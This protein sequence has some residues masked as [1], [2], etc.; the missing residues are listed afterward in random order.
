MSAFDIAGLVFL[1]LMAAFGV[2]LLVLSA[3][4]IALEVRAELRR[5]AHH[6]KGDHR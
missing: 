3:V 5:S 1:Y 6:R 2:L 4:A